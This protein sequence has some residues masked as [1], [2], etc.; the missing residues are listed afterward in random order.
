MAIGDTVSHRPTQ[1]LN[2]RILTFH[3]SAKNAKEPATSPD[4]V[5]IPAM[6][7]ELPVDNLLLWPPPRIHMCASLALQIMYL[8]LGDN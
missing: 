5:S 7:A 1:S 3:A 8:E 2:G 6:A 4:S